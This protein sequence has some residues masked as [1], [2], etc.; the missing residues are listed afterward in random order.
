VE[1]EAAGTK[2]LGP[3]ECCGN[4]S[5][6]V[7]GYLH[8]GPRT[9]AAYY[10]QWTLGRVPEEGAHFDFIVG[11]W[12]DGTTR[13]DRVAIAMELQWTPQG[14]SFMV[15]DAATRPVAHSELIGKVL[16]RA[17]VIGH[18]MADTVFGLADVVWISDDRIAEVSG[19]GGR[20]RG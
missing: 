2:D 9:V 17:E 12:G 4:L 6:T 16:A 3:C 15:I 13:A 20:T 11:S 8:D 7:W 10:V 18:P 5:R 14:P 19:R 1:L